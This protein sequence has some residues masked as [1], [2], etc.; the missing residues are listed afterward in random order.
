VGAARPQILMFHKGDRGIRKLLNRTGPV[1]NRKHTSRR[2][3]AR[4][5]AA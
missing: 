1:R 5:C 4:L 3:F 2:M